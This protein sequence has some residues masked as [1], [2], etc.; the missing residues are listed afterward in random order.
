MES[1]LVC[2]ISQVAGNDIAVTSHNCVL[3]YKAI[4]GDLVRYIGAGF[5]TELWGDRFVIFACHMLLGS[6]DSSVGIVTLYGLDGKGA[7]ILVGGD[8]FRTCPDRQWG[9][10]SLLYRGADNPLARPGKKQTNVS[11]RMAW[12]SFGALLCWKTNKHYDSSRLDVV[13]IARV[14]DMLPG[15]FPSWSGYKGFSAPRYNGYRV[16]FSRVKRPGSG[17]DHRI[18]SSAEVEERVELY[19]Y[20]G[21]SWLVL[22]WPLPLLIISVIITSRVRWAVVVERKGGRE[23]AYWET[24]RKEQASAAVTITPALFW[25]SALRKI[26]E[27]RR[28]DC[29]RD[30]SLK[31]RTR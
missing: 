31:S 23:S 27:K 24:W 13:E 3:V 15:L 2:D 30:Q 16:F 18:P 6:R 17:V 9:P 10:P 26:A 29:E 1:G 4:V 12:I 14:P 21:P 5:F 20:S 25:G 28:C 11:V 8:I 22:G 19:V 7:W